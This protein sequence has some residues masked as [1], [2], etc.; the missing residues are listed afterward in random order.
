MNA[1]GP[2]PAGA[3][4]VPARGGNAL[5]ALLAVAQFLVVLDATIVT[6]ALP[7]LGLDLGFAQDDLSWVVNAYLLAF[8]GLLLLGGRIADVAGRRRVFIIGL[9]VF[10]VASLLAGLAQSTGWL[11]TRSRALDSALCGPGGP[12]RVGRRI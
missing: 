5:L 11:I 6:V 10:A 1:A 3:G 2:A 7:S 12:R 8:A 4:S 9:V